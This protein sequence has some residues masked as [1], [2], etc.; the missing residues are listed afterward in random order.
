MG[1]LSAAPSGSDFPRSW[2][3]R[4]LSGPAADSPAQAYAHLGRGHS[5][6]ALPPLA[7][8][9]PPATVASWLLLGPTNMCQCLE[10][11]LCRPL[12]GNLPH[13]LWASSQMFPNRR[14]PPRPPDKHGP[15][16]P[17]PACSAGSPPSGIASCRGNLLCPRKCKS[18][19]ERDS[20]SGAIVWHFL[21]GIGP[22]PQSRSG[23]LAFL[24]HARLPRVPCLPGALGWDCVEEAAG[25]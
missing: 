22:R 10:G 13:F 19:C 25:S 8:P 12:H 11:S 18:G 2:V 7:Y 1:T 23:F 6:V 15:T 16:G 5:C 3:R 4:V 24:R 20:V 9:S 17:S 14:G 21:L